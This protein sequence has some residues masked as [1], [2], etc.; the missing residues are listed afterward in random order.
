VFQDQLARDGIVRI[1]QLQSLE[2]TELMKRYGS[3]GIR[4]YHLAR[5]EDYRLVSANDD[6]RSI[7]AET[8]FNSDVAAYAELERILWRLAEKVSRRAKVSSFA[9]QTVT[10]KLKTADF[11]LRTRNTTLAD[12]TLMAGRIFEAAAPMLRREADGTR[13]RLIGVSISRLKAASADSEAVTLDARASSRTKAEIAMDVLR[14]RFG[15]D[16]VERGIAFGTDEV[17]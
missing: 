1:A 9:G 12:S 8:T 16:A 17:D 3:M 10:L 2:K 4:L 7:G 11:K 6:A 5:G 13:Y 15:R 14:S